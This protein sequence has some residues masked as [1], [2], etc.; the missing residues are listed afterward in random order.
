MYHMLCV[1]RHAIFVFCSESTLFFLVS[2]GVQHTFVVNAQE[3]SVD[4]V[5]NTIRDL[6]PQRHTPRRL[7]LIQTYVIGKERIL[8]QIHKQLGLS[9]FVSQRKFDIY[10]CLDWPGIPCMVQHVCTLCHM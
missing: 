9:I 4:Y 1:L 10:Q 5:V 7:F 8:V 6:L 2:V 3:E